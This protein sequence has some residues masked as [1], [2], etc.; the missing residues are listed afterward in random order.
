[1]NIA[2]ADFALLLSSK[3]VWNPTR[4]ANNWKLLTL[5][6]YTRSRRRSV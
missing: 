6:Q 2:F 3:S 1:V 5:M 4:Y